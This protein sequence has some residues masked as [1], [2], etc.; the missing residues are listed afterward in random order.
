MLYSVIYS[1]D[2]IVHCSCLFEQVLK[3]IHLIVIVVY[4]F[5]LNPFLAAD[6]FSTE[7]VEGIFVWDCYPESSILE[8]YFVI[9]HP[10]EQWNFIG[11]DGLCPN[12]VFTEIPINSNVVTWRINKESE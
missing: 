3:S 12:L 4:D 11:R 5:F 7:S 10:Y 2:A 9:L 6:E 1:V 8:R